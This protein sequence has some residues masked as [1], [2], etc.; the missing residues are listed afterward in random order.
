MITFIKL[1]LAHLLG[2]FM[3][4]PN[5]WV[6]EKERLKA[7][8]P[9]IY[10][11]VLLHGAL[12]F[13]FIGKLNFWIWALVI[14]LAHCIIDL[15]KLYFQKE[16][17]KRTWFWLDQLLHI[18]VLI[19]VSCF[20]ENKPIDFSGLW[21]GKSILLYTCI[22]LQTTPA[23]VFVK[24]MISAWTPSYNNSIETDSLQNA[25][26]YIGILERL[27]VFIFI[28]INHWEGVGFLLAAKSVFRFGDLREARDRK[29]TEY[30]MIGTF[31]SFGIA[32]VTGILFKAIVPYFINA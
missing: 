26:K 11:H 29:L 22:L 8:S 18:I 2:D 10:F 27:F 12:S 13:L 31:L 16:R 3:L 30:V 19:I 6:R 15:A 21:S 23:A 17:N 14:T 32:I 1:L 4:Q 28:I 20:W 25:G 9:K 7:R 24:M 5:S